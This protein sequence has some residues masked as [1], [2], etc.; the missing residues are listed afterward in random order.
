MPPRPRTMWQLPQFPLPVKKRSPSTTSPA[1]TP[2]AAGAAEGALS[3]MTKAVIESSSASA[4][5]KAGMPPPGMPVRIRSRTASRVV[6]R[7]RRTSMMLG[8]WPPPVPS[9]AWQPEHLAWNWLLPVAGVW[10][11][12]D[13]TKQTAQITNVEIRIV[14]IDRATQRELLPVIS[15]SAWALPSWDCPPLRIQAQ[16]IPDIRQ[17]QESSRFWGCPQVQACGRCAR[18]P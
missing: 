2:P 9:S 17:P 7:G 15:K 14:V 10:A 5:G 8:P 11:V 18:F 6:A 13:T 3:D 12:A 1:T 16:D 4:S